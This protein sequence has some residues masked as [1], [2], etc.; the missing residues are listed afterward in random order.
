MDAYKLTPADIAGIRGTG[1]A[2]RV[3]VGDVERF[4]NDVENRDTIQASPMRVAV[5]DGMRRSW[6][7]PF[8]T[9]GMTCNL[10][11]LMQDRR[12]RP[13]RPGA[14]VYAIRALAIAL[15]E[16]PTVACRLVGERL[17]K[18]TS[19][20]IA[21]AVEV[22]DGVRTPVVPPANE[23]DLEQTNTRYDELL[24]MARERGGPKGGVPVATISNY[25]LIGIEWATP[26]PMPEESLILGIGAVKN[27]PVWEKNAWGRIRGCEL[28]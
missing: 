11:P 17:V 18:P 4:L 6:S 24:K 15:A 23:V 20:D 7:R 13:G 10:D 1:R 19:I 5:A 9:V 26:V 16:C 25:A 12:T 22:P 28:T 3:N 2:G 14:T 27:M 8:A 21:F